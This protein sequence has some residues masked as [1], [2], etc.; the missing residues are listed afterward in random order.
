M[1][2][3]PHGH[4]SWVM[5]QR[6]PS[7][8]QA[9]EM[10]LLWGVAGVTRLDRIRISGVEPLLLQIERSQ[11]MWYMDTWS[12]LMPQERPAKPFLFSESRGKR[13]VGRPNTRRID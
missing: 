7:R 13:R 5:I 8:I 11:L 6:T 12:E 1:T 2:P 4:E 9:A 3:T 10:R